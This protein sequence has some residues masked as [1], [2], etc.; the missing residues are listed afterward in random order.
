MESAGLLPDTII[1]FLV[2][3]FTLE[4]CHHARRRLRDIREHGTD[5]SRLEYLQAKILIYPH[6]RR[7]IQSFCWHLGDKC[8]HSLTPFLS[9]SAAMHITIWVAAMLLITLLI[10]TYKTAGPALVFTVLEHQAIKTS[11]LTIN[12]VK[13]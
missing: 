12:T 9:N 8:F 5:T 11:R 10:A 13:S 1:D 6:F 7:Y 2:D 4:N 3:R